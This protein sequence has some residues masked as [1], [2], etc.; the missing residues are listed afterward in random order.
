[1]KYIE[2]KFSGLKISAD[3]VLKNQQKEEEMTSSYS[4]QILK[5]TPHPVN[6]IVFLKYYFPL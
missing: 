4:A 3:H 2:W 6:G 1:M 5:E